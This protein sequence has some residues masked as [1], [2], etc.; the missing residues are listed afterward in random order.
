MQINNPALDNIDS[1]PSTLTETEYEIL[2]VM[3][4]WPKPLTINS[5]LSVYQRYKRSVVLQLWEQSMDAKQELI[6]RISLGAFQFGPVIIDSKYIPKIAPF[7]F[8]EDDIISYKHQIR[9][10]DGSTPAFILAKDKM[11][12]IPNKKFLDKVS[13]LLRI[14]IPSYLKLKRDMR[15]LEHLSIACERSDANE[16][17]KLYYINPSLMSEW[18]KKRAEYI[19]KYEKNPQ[20]LD[21]ESFTFFMLYTISKSVRLFHE[22]NPKQKVHI[23]D[24]RGFKDYLFYETMN[25]YINILYKRN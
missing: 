6:G 13:A 10:I 12:M 23:R 15:N 17:K 2:L 16:K 14:R 4:R 5:I 21:E 11:H 20:T 25:E 9:K 8:D 18:K 1:I 22:K 24:I 3:L 7:I 19:E